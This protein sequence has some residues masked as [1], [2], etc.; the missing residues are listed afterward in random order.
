MKKGFVFI[1]LVVVLAVVGLLIGLA[2]TNVTGLRSRASLTGVVDT[3][4]SDLKTQQTKAMSDTV[5][6]GIVQPGFGV[7]F[8][9]NQYVLFRGTAYNASDTSNSVIAL[10]QG[11]T[12][13]VINLPNSS[14]VF[15]S[16][17][18]DVVGWESS[19]STISVYE[20]D[21]HETKTFQFN[22]YGVIATIE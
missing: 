22:R 11:V 17:S 10:D 14:L 7:R 19:A 16:R 18:G 1:E 15:A 8:E 5:E 6:A 20:S 21:T 2:V 3:L 12:F 13:S 9:T 4:T